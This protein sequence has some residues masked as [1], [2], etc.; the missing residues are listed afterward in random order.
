MG[1][2]EKKELDLSWRDREQPG[3]WGSSLHEGMC[4]LWFRVV[5][6]LMDNRVNHNPILP[7][8]QFWWEQSYCGNRKPSSSSLPP[9]NQVFCLHWYWLS[10]GAV[11]KHCVDFKAGRHSTAK[12]R[13]TTSIAIINVKAWSWIQMGGWANLSVKEWDISIGKGFQLHFSDSEGSTLWRVNFYCFSF[14][15][16]FPIE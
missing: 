6:D 9:S 8:S 15:L 14:C 11:N 4:M 3:T 5:G 13:I 10:S 1:L 12:W 16:F 2:W 7:A